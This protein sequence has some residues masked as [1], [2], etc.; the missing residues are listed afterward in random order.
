MYTLGINAAFQDPAA[1]LM[2]DGMMIAAV[3]EERFTRRRH[4]QRSHRL[5]ADELPFHAIDYCLGEAGITLAEVQHVAYAHDPALLMA[6]HPAEN[7]LLLARAVGGEVPATQQEALFQVAIVDAPHRLVNG[8]A[9]QVHLRGTGQTSSF[10]WHSVAHHLAHA[11]SAFFP[12]PY[13]RAAVLTLDGRG[14]HITTSYALGDAGWLKPIGEMHILHSRQVTL[15]ETVLELAA[16]L[17]AETQVEHLCLAG[18]VARNWALSTRLRDETPFE[19]VWAAP[20]AGDAGTALGAALLVDAQERGKRGAYRMQ[21]AF[22]GPAYGDE[23]IAALLRLTQLPSRRIETIAATVAELL[24][25]QQIVGWFQGRIAFGPNALGA[26]SIL[27][28]PLGPAALEH[29][30]ELNGYAERH[31]PVLVVL[32]E[33]ANTWF[34]GAEESPFGLFLYD[35]RPACAARLPALEHTGGKA[36][37]QTIRREQHPR[38]YDLV[39][40]FAQLTGV[41]LLINSPFEKHGEPGVCTPRDALAYFL[42]TPLDALALE[43]FLVEKG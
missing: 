8:A 31:P 34:V 24:V 39:K 27:A 18:E 2:R 29:L 11:A 12:S 35:L 28:S 30:N 15:E 6:R 7:P 20:T 13:E 25:K 1:C 37:V 5:I 23:E 42:E 3:E 4:N 41:P 9:Q 10:R 19:R 26:R 14:E 32:A 33:E 17:H 40:A 38:L 22:L 21:H 36:R 43:S 16:W